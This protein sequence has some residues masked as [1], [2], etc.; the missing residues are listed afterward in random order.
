MSLRHR[1]DRLSL[2]VQRSI[3]YIHKYISL[4]PYFRNLKSITYGNI[5]N[6]FIRDSLEAV[7]AAAPLNH[8]LI[9]RAFV[10]RKRFARGT[11]KAITAVVV[12]KD[13]KAMAINVK[14]N[15]PHYHFTCS[16]LI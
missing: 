10:I 5:I 7:R 14:V 9:T 6:E 2:Q 4:Q 12:A 13:S 16:L 8:A 15:L 11:L 1:V 3:R